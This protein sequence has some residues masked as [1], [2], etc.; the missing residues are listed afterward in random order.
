[1]RV[2]AGDIDGN[3]RDDILVGNGWGSG[4]GQPT[5]WVYDFGSTITCTLF[6]IF[7]SYNIDIYV[8]AGDVTGD[9]KKEIIIGYGSEC[10]TY[11]FLGKTYLPDPRVRVFDNNLTELTTFQVNDSNFTGGSTIAV[12]PFAGSPR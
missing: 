7:E 4:G 2:G 10:Y 6:H 11:T 3:G 5:L 8:A 1:M 9:A 12:G